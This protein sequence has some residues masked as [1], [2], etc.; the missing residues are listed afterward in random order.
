MLAGRNGLV[1]KNVLLFAAGFG[2]PALLAACGDA[3][4]ESSGATTESAPNAPPTV[5]AQYE[6]GF[7][8]TNFWLRPMAIAD[9]GTGGSSGDDIGQVSQA[10]ES[11]LPNARYS[12]GGAAGAAGTAGAGG[13]G[14]SN[15]V[16]LEQLELRTEANWNTAACGPTPVHGACARIRLIN[17]YANQ[18]VFRSYFY[19]TSLTPPTSCTTGCSIHVWI[20]SPGSNIQTATPDTGL[21]GVTAASG[22]GGAPGLWRYG[23]LEHSAVEARSP[24][25]W[26]AFVGTGTDTTGKWNFHFV[27]QVRGMLVTPTR[28]GSLLNGTIDKAPFYTSLGTGAGLIAAGSNMQSTPDGRYV[29]FS[30]GATLASTGSATGTKVYRYDTTTGTTVT[31]SVPTSSPNAP[32]GCTSMSP[33]VSS[34]G[35]LVVYQSSGCDLGF[36]TTSREIYMRNVNTNT[37]FMITHAFGSTTTPADGDSQWA[38]I[39]ANGN[40]VTLV[41]SSQNMPPPAL[42]RTAGRTVYDVYRYNIGTDTFQRANIGAYLAP[43]TWPNYSQYHPDISGDGSRVVFDTNSQNLV[44][45]D[46]A[47]NSDVFLYDFGGAGL[48]MLSV[49]QTGALLQNSI[50]SLPTISSDSSTVAFVCT[51]ATPAAYVSS[52]TSTG[53]RQHVYWR[54]ATSAATLKMVDTD[55]TGAEGGASVAAIPPALNSNGQLV[56]Y[57]G[58]A[59]NLLRTSACDTPSGTCMAVPTVGFS[60]FVRDMASPDP[61]VQR[62]FLVSQIRSKANTAALPFAPAPNGIPVSYNARVLDVIGLRDGA[63]AVYMVGGGNSTDWAQCPS[64][65]GYQVYLSPFSDALYQ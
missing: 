52:P 6:G 20:P 8:G 32:S 29:V 26:V 39:S 40:Y 4:S 45:G 31:I 46:T 3:G 15:E 22:N 49:S 60:P 58:I 5:L 10:V 33:S 17:S 50:C 1:R 64:S 59:A 13:A 9:Q 19:L 47:V 42:N 2:V 21:L 41:S 34:D 38:R 25:R 53:G 63:T 30:S 36:G 23:L 44:R 18:D 7:D 62:S 57:G 12:T 14:Q 43:T 28:R 65:G 24:E 16:L 51:T 27:A 56:G 48:S 11:D 55:P 54:S 61:E 37:T 35:N